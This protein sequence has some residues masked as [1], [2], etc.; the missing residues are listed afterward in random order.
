MN[1]RDCIALSLLAVSAQSCKWLKGPSEQGGKTKTNADNSQSD[2]PF[3][4]GFA[5]KHNI[6][7]TVTIVTTPD[8]PPNR[9]AH[10]QVDFGTLD[11]ATYL[12]LM[13][14]YGGSTALVGYDKTRKY[15]LIDFLPPKMQALVNRWMP[16]TQEE[17]TTL[18]TEYGVGLN[19]TLPVK[20]Y[21]GG[22]NC[23]TSVY[24][25]LRDID[26]PFEKQTLKSYYLADVFFEL[27][28]AQHP[29]VQAFEILEGEDIEKRNE[30]RMP[31]DVLVVHLVGVSLRGNLAHAAIWIDDDLYFEKT[32][33]G[34]DHPI[35]LARWSDVIGTY[36]KKGL[37]EEGSIQ[38]LRLEK[39][40]GLTLPGPEKYAIDVELRGFLSVE[41]EKEYV[42]QLIASGAQLPPEVK[43]KKRFRDLPKELDR[44][45]ISEFG[46]GSDLH[47]IVSVP[48]V[49]DP[50]TGRAQA[51]AF[52]GGLDTTFNANRKD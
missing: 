15:E 6:P 29:N 40:D 36:E 41:E 26:V 10:V 33:I 13:N 28:F 11:E 47:K 7:H 20:A 44:L 37:R 4:L 32:N 39:K 9:R 5:K 14:H 27:D 22:H 18:P 8:A 48:L 35:R 16:L 50:A 3:E 1:R 30:G 49:R 21:N 25:V 43:A 24:E 2:K 19:L 52:P 51:P 34:Y 23:W 17:L 46:P 38:F 42:E 31:G 12:K 45:L